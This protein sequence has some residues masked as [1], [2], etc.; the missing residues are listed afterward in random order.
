MYVKLV[1]QYGKILIKLLEIWFKLFDQFIKLVNYSLFKIGK[2]L[3]LNI[4]FIQVQLYMKY[5]Q[6][7]NFL[8]FLY[9]F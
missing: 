9:E 5:M 6:Y 4:I 3:Q 1:K 7:I 8:F 2:K